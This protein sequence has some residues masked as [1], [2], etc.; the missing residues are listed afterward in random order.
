[1]RF[2]DHKVAV[3]VDAHPFRLAQLDLGHLPRQH[4]FAV[5]RKFLDAT[6]HVRDV[7]IVLLIDGE[8][9]WFVEFPCPGSPSANDLNH[10]KE[11]AVHTR[12]AL[13]LLATRSEQNHETN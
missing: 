7:K 9:A 4:K 13:L 8:T 10:A 5:R 11:P 6:C 3:M 12:L 1:M 2:N